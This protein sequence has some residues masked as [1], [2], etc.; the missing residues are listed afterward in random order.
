VALVEGAPDL[1]AALHFALAE[2]RRD[3]VAAVAMLGASLA[4][5][6]DALPLF[7]GKRVRI[8]PH[9]DDAGQDA[10]ARWER[11]LVDAGAEVDCFSLANVRKVDGSA[12][13]DLNDL[14]FLNADDFEEDRALWRLFD[15]VGVGHE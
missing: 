9:L 13:K 11:E 2:G 12:V 7:T 3:H 8:F 15:F 6:D 5:P 14:A 10:A 1:L 4:I